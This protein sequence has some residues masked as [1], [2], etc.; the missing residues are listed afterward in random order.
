TEISLESWSQYLIQ[1]SVSAEL[2][3]LNALSAVI[4]SLQTLRTRSESDRR[5][6]QTNVPEY[7][8]RTQNIKSWKTLCTGLGQ[9]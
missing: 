3:S 1:G 8:A 5:P 6:A 2:L 9:V 4:D 7:I